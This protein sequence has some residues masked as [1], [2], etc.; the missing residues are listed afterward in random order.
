MCAQ[1]TV[2]VKYFD[3][4]QIEWSP[5]FT[6][7][8]LIKIFRVL[9][10]SCWCF[11]LIGLVPSKQHKVKL[12][13]CRRIRM[14]RG[15]WL[16]LHYALENSL[17]ARRTSGC[18]LCLSCTTH[19]PEWKKECFETEM[20]FYVCVIWFTMVQFLVWLDQVC[21][22]EWRRKQMANFTF[23]RYLLRVHI[24]D[25]RRAISTDVDTF[26]HLSYA[27]IQSSWHTCSKDAC[28]LWDT[29]K[30][31]RRMLYV[32]QFKESPLPELD[33]QQIR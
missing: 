8:F 14:T 16:Y 13:V 2:L 27:L 4:I 9:I 5:L 19:S 22:E 29:C 1:H 32:E 33:H 12:F 23:T 15:L 30:Y 28:S 10:N 11:K 25:V 21:I 7:A 17:A 3:P 6:R 20:C 18:D 24:V 31:L 26:L